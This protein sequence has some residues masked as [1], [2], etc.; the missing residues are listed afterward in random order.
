[1]TEGV[2]LEFGDADAMLWA[3][4]KI[5]DRDGIGDTLA[6][7][8]DH[9]AEVWGKGACALAITVKGNSLP[10]HDPRIKRSLALIYAVNP[11]GPDHQSS[12]HDPAYTKAAG[13]E[14]RRRLELLGLDKQLDPSDLSDEKVRFAYETQKFFSLLDSASVCQ[15]VYGPSSQLYG[16][17]H[18][19]QAL[20]AVTG[21]DLTLDELQEIGER[22]LNLMRAFNAREGL[23][24]AADTLPKKL[25]KDAISDEELDRAL[26]TY[27]ELAGW[28]VAT[29]IP[30]PETLARLGVAAIPE[31]P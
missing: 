18:L 7:G 12:E 29:G 17:D 11:F 23:G 8:I 21:W 26:D 5:I 20:N 15:F 31:T 25:R 16:P 13:V 22:R 28:D 9:A 1:M 3:L 30:M 10:A 2:E 24:R 27:Y 6:E 4:G 14:E 19:V